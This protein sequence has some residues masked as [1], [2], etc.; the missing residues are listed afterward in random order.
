MTAALAAVVAFAQPNATKQISDASSLE[1]F[2]PVKNVTF[3]PAIPTPQSVFGFEI[4]E[5]YV[6]WNGVLRYME[7]LDKASDR[8]SIET[9]GSTFEHRPFI[10]VRITSPENQK[11]LESIREE[12]LKITDASVS[13]SLDLDK[14]PLVVDLMG[15]IH[16][17]EASGVNALIVVAYYFT[18]A[19]DENVKNLLDNTVLIITPGQNP[20]GINKFAHWMNTTVSENPVMDMNSVE[21]HEPSPSARGNHYWNDCNRD[22][23]NIQFPEGK[24]AVAM[25]LRWMPNVVLDLHEMSSSS[26]RA[27][28]Y[29]SPGDPGRTYHYIPQMNQDLTKEISV[30]TAAAFDSLQVP[31]FT[32]R[33]FDDYFVGKG[34]CYGDI[35]GS[36][37][38]LH[39]QA[40]SRARIRMTSK[41]GPQTWAQTIRNQSV[42]SVTLAYR[43]LSMKKKLL[44]YQRDF[45][46]NESKTASADRNRGY[47]FNA[48]GDRGTAY[49]FVETLLGHG[50]DVYKDASRKD[51][52]VVPFNQKHYYKIKSIF[53]DITTFQDST[54]Y[55]ISTWTMS[56]AYNLDYAE[57]QTLPSLGEKILKAEFPQG[58]VKGG[59][60]AYGY[61]FS[62]KEYYS[63]RMMAALQRA[64]VKLSVAKKP[65]D[66]GTGKH[67]VSFPAGTIVIAAKEQTLSREKLFSLVKEQSEQCGVDVQALNP[68]SSLKDY[69]ISYINRTDVREP[70]TLIVTGTGAYGG[71]QKLGE[72]WYLL[73]YRYNMN[74]TIADFDERMVYSSFS[75]SN[76]NTVVVYGEM[77]KASDSTRKLYKEFEKWLSEGGTLVIY[78]RGC[79]LLGHLGLPKITRSKEN[80]N[81]ISGV[82]LNASYKKDSPLFWGYDCNELPIF[83]MSDCT[84]KLP[85]E[86]SAVMNYTS[87]PYLSGYAPQAKKEGYAGAPVVATMPHGQGQVVFI[88]ED[89]NFRSFWFGTS[90]ILTNA[91]FFGD[92]LK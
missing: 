52:F 70:K 15:S 45:Y 11:N 77:P 6:D 22:W 78:E 81:H 62:T 20:D 73:D 57:V 48:R 13:S 9:F 1:F 24:N 25:Y 28:Y 44:E 33:G 67:K 26:K 69:S 47:V 90:H 91:L 39:E 87:A 75:F 36:V 21:Y 88:S 89:T 42:A 54:F 29:F 5:D 43:S 64:G 17:N 19:E 51:G 18:A 12:H 10:Q 38:L 8:V 50:I 58:T 59:E 35:Q 85:E 7:M 37:C 41:W 4:G 76:Y 66:Y 2:L 27:L 49:H 84:Y 71:Y 80:D 23:L 72:V 34:A 60:S 31:F 92:K 30:T 53:E 79:N 61:A 3:N 40:A 82:I 68:A 55:D 83:K 65:F 63:P 56:R 32:E 74:H 16:G 86:A 14:M 46:I